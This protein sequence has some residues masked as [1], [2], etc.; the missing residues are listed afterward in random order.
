MMSARQAPDSG[1]LTFRSE[2][3]QGIARPWA[4]NLCVDKKEIYA[5]GEGRG[6]SDGTPLTGSIQDTAP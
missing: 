2:I 6:S 1:L 3:S 4:G 5:P